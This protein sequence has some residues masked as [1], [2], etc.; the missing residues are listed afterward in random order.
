[1]KSSTNTVRPTHKHRQMPRYTDMH[2][3]YA[4]SKTFTDTGTHIQTHRCKQ[5][6]IYNGSQIHRHT[7][8]TERQTY[9]DRYRAHIHVHIDKC[10][11]RL[12]DAHTE[13]HKDIQ[14][15]TKT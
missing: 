1:M 2:K 13:T 6:N 7:R 12:T 15:D 10:T 5:T 9:T 11:Q 3:G 14:A 4:D 8:H